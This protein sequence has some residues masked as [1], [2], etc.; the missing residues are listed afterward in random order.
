[1]GLSDSFIVAKTESPDCGLSG[2]QPL[3]SRDGWQYARVDPYEYIDGVD[4][5]QH[6]ARAVA[7]PALF[8]YI[9][10]SAEAAIYW[11]DGEDP[12]G[13]LAIGPSYDSAHPD[14]KH[15][16]QWNDPAAHREAAD[17]LGA[18]STA[19]APSATTGAA[20]VDALASLE[21]PKFAAEETRSV[22]GESGMSV[23]FEDL[24]GFP[25]LW[26]TVFDK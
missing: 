20:I 15:D 23:I 3:G 5:L 16:R 8:T 11:S 24:M 2:T 7:A 4:I 22:D 21:S 13:W 26:E 14:V 25:P 12:P 17:A 18:W 1:M 9:I 10:D 19:F 6:S